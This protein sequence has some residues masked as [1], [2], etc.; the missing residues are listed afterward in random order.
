MNRAI[1][2]HDS[3]LHSVITVGDRCLLQ[4]R[5]AY[6]HESVG[7]VGI[8]P[9][10]GFAQD[11]D[12]IF[13]EA[14]VILMLAILP[15]RISEGR[16]NVAGRALDNLLPLPSSFSGKISFSAVTVHGESLELAASSMTSHALGEKEFIEHFP[17]SN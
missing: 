14:T 8:D 3:T 4:L 11:V 2:L 9:G 12:L 17:G 1:E 7:R 15:C 13:A 16:M 5:P 10:D 6:V